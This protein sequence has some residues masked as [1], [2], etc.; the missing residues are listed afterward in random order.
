MSWLGDNVGTILGAV[1]G[2]YGG[3][4]SNAAML[5]LNR[6][7]REWYERMSNTAHQREVKD[8]RAAG[9]NPILSANRGA[10]SAMIGTPQLSNPF[11]SFGSDLASGSNAATNRRTQKMQAI[12]L[13]AQGEN[14]RANTAKSW[15]EARS[16]EADANI[17]ESMNQA[18]L[19]AT[20]SLTPLRQSATELNK[21]E[22]NY[23][24]NWK[25]KLAEQDIMWKTA[26]R[27]LKFEQAFNLR[28]ML[29]Y[30]QNE[31]A[32]RAESYHTQSV[33]N[34]ST[35]QLQAT[36]RILNNLTAGRISWESAVLE[37]RKYNIDLD[38]AMKE[39]DYA[40]GISET[41]DEAGQGGAYDKINSLIATLGRWRRDLDL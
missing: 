8:L 24:Q 1:G 37:A 38:S 27:L 30:Q 4:R 40:K 13:N 15:A 17:R 10:S 26:D 12:Y 41:P 20:K 32:A 33:L 39:L 18:V 31:S 29:P 2:V 21:A 6:E 25:P 14:L 7:N 19:E 34:M 35:S 11:G 3:M 9:L 5:Q 16:A 22:T 23:S 36:Q 28:Q